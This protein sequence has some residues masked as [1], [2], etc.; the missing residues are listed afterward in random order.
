MLAAMVFVPS[1]VQA[2]VSRTD[3][4]ALVAIYD[5]TGGDNWRDNTNWKSQEPVGEWYEV[6]VENGVV[7]ELAW[8][9][10]I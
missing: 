2:Q 8:K 5:A 10:I 4:L 1:V 3:S 6:T 7:T 9:T